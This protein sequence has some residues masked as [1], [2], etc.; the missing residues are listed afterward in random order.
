MQTFK[1]LLS[2]IHHVD[3]LVG[4]FTLASLIEDWSTISS[5]HISEINIKAK[6]TN[7][8]SNSHSIFI[9]N[10][11][12]EVSTQLHPVIMKAARRVLVDEI[13]SSIIPDFFLSKKAERQDRPE[14]TYQDNRKHDSSK[15]KV[16]REHYCSLI[17]FSV[18][19]FSFHDAKKSL[20]FFCRK[21]LLMYF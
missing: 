14:P 20:T 4:P 12:D 11:S 1:I 13:L 15:G 18:I 10:V 2:Q 19:F 16:I 3:N 17:L 9:S 5:Q 6:V 8:H 21:W 7:K